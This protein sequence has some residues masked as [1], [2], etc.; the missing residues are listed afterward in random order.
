VTGAQAYRTVYLGDC[1]TAHPTTAVPPFRPSTGAGGQRLPDIRRADRATPVLFK[2]CN[3]VVT[4]GRFLAC[5]CTAGILV[6]V[7]QTAAVI[8]WP[9]L[10]GNPLHP[11]PPPPP[12]PLFQR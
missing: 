12:L 11:S 10:S 7:A 9:D 2:S 5:L 8:D 1:T 6:A 4:R 3:M